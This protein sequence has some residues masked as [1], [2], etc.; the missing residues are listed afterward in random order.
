MIKLNKSITNTVI[1]TLNEKL[2]KIPLQFGNMNAGTYGT[3][4][5]FDPNLYY[6][7]NIQLESDAPSLDNK[8]I[9]VYDDLN[10]L[11]TTFVVLNWEYLDYENHLI[12]VYVEEGSL[13]IPTGYKFSLS[14]TFYVDLPSTTTYHLKL[15]NSLTGKVYNDIV[16]RDSSTNKDRYNMF[17]IR[18]DG[19]IL[20]E[21]IVPDSFV[22]VLENGKIY[23]V[24]GPILIDSLGT[25]IIP[26][27]TYI[28][29]NE[30]K[31]FNILGWVT[32]PE[33]FIATDFSQLSD[34]FITFNDITVLMDLPTGYYDYSISDPND[35][36]ILEIGKLLIEFDETNKIGYE[37]TIEKRI[38]YEPR[39][40]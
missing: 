40:K 9:Y 10:K 15:T 38:A 34:S 17:K 33:H 21:L 8:T 18:N 14:N 26:N 24:D 30:I 23:I 31:D 4:S 11:Y 36:T 39:K 19:E 12:T 27:D 6:Q 29:F 35:I 13:D 1:T 28:I 7:I 37:P 25:L 32:N 2:S 16:I 22:E 5:V 3:S 20:P